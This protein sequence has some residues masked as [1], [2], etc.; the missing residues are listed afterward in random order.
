MSAAFISPSHSGAGGHRPGCLELPRS[1]LRAFSYCRRQTGSQST[2][3]LVSDETELRRSLLYQARRAVTHDWYTGV[4]NP[5]HTLRE[6]LELSGVDNHVLD[7]CDPVNWNAES[8]N[9]A[10]SKVRSNLAGAD[11]RMNKLRATFLVGELSRL[12]RMPTAGSGRS[13]ADNLDLKFIEHVGCYADDNGSA[14]ALIYL[15]KILEVVHHHQD[16]RVSRR[17]ALLS[18]DSTRAII[19]RC[20]NCRD[21]NNVDAVYLA[22]AEDVMVLGYSR[23]AVRKARR[24]TSPVDALIIKT[25]S[26]GALLEAAVAAGCAANAPD[27]PGGDNLPRCTLNA[28]LLNEVGE[29]WSG[30]NSFPSHA[31]FP[32]LLAAALSSDPAT[33]DARWHLG[34]YFLAVAAS[35]ASVEAV[36]GRLRHALDRPESYTS[37]RLEMPAFPPRAHVRPSRKYSF[38]TRAGLPSPRTA[39]WWVSAAPATSHDLTLHPSASELSDASIGPGGGGGGGWFTTA[40]PVGR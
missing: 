3:P 21:V 34:R 25:E 40:G 7:W 6:V 37:A 26:N 31:V 15:G 29:A 1:L 17:K 20:Y 23:D 30:G 22:V 12:L 36:A 13:P 33:R 16:L 8:R 38:S 9:L 11:S 28:L 4:R 35:E 39:S 27:L 18:D 5:D 14:A 32:N 24:L 19:N 2:P 10:V